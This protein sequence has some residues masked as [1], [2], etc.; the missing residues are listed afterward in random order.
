ML[1][2]SFK[3]GWYSGKCNAWMAVAKFSDIVL[4]SALLKQYYYNREQTWLSQIQ[5][6]CPLRWGPETYRC[7]SWQGLLTLLLKTQGL[8]QRKS[9]H[10]SQ[11]HDSVWVSL[12]R[13]FAPW[14][15]KCPWALWASVFKCKLNYLGQLGPLRAINAVKAA[16]LSSCSTVWDL[17]Q[18]VL[19]E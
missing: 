10:F 3:C 13:V 15:R 11:A 14:I 7:P 4:D 2:P 9:S 1:R 19:Q 6:L 17:L 16:F 12:A 5:K 8:S 18:I